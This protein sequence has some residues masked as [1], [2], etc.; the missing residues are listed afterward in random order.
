MKTIRLFAMYNNFIYS[1][2]IINFCFALG[3][4]G[5]GQTKYTSIPSLH[6]FFS[7]SIQVI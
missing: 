5:V 7:K 6:H 3:F 1:M 4:N 2:F